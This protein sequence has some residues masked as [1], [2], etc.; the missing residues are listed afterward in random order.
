M[1]TRNLPPKLVMN[2]C[3]Q[4]ARASPGRIIFRTS[5][6]TFK[7]IEGRP[8]EILGTFLEEHQGAAELTMPSGDGGQ[9]A[10]G[11]TD[12]LGALFSAGILL[13]R[14]AMGGPGTSGDALR[15]APQ[16]GFFAGLP[17]T[18]G[19]GKHHE[20]IRKST[21]LLLGAGPVASHAAFVLM[22]AGVSRLLVGEARSTRADDL[23]AGSLLAGAAP[24]T[25]EGFHTLAKQTESVSEV[26]HV[27]LGTE[28]ELEAAM[29]RA[30]VTI[31]APEGYAMRKLRA[32]NR[33]ALRAG[34]PWI[35]AYMDGLTGMVGPVL[36][37]KKTGCFA[38]FELRDASHRTHREPHTT[39]HATFAPADRATTPCPPGAASI[40]GGI[41]GLEAMKVLA[42]VPSPAFGRGF[43]LRFDE[44]EITPYK[45]LRLPLCPECGEPIYAKGG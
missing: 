16:L 5:A 34:K 27:V 21:V 32:V 15:F 19:P 20:S 44:F 4:V 3:I 36:V 7:E 13:D 42:D 1:K 25:A 10:P 11:L 12:I 6:G 40:L 41:A 45:L 38:C 9:E 43:V 30:S 18:A 29:S 33:A 22:G 35:P 14:A 26:E 31:V 8:A 37:P 23:N 28:T 24:S 2:P 39:F 17:T